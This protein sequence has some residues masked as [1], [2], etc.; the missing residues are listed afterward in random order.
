MFRHYLFDMQFTKTIVKELLS[1]ISI[2]QVLQTRLDEVNAI[3]NLKLKDL[4]KA[5]EGTLHVSESNGVVQYYHKTSSS[6]KHGNYIASNNAK[7]AQ[8]LA[9]ADYDRKL[10]A[11]LRYE[12]Q[13]LQRA[14]AR[15]NNFDRKHGVAE[16][17]YTKLSKSKQ[18]LIKPIRLSDEE[19]AAA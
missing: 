6:G 5:P 12:T 8:Q 2:V 7:L 17:L 9:Q 1:P 15:Y 10:V 14:L 18:K 13:F 3:L 4:K 19:Y 16:T 11:S